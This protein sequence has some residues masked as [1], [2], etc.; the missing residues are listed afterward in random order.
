MHHKVRCFVLS[1]SYVRITAIGIALG[2]SATLTNAATV[3]DSKIARVEEGLL[4]IAAVQV[5]KPATILIRLRDYDVP[6][7]SIAVI[8]GGRIAWAKGYGMADANTGRRV[9]ATTIFQAASLSKPITALGVLSLVREKRFTLDQDV[10]EK[11]TSWK[12]P[13]GDFH[14]TPRMLLNH[15]GGVNVAGF[16]G[17]PVGAPLPS[18]LDVLAG[19]PPS[20]SPPIAIESTPGQAAN[21][22]GGGYEVLQQLVTD[23]AGQPFEGFMQKA[24]LRPLGMK[25]SVFEEPLAPTRR[26][27]AAMGHYA[28][29]QQIQGGFRVMPELAAA[30]LW[31]TPSD[32]ARYV[33][34]IQ[35]SNEG[36][37]AGPITPIL[38]RQTL[39][40][41]LGQH[42]LGPVISGADEAVRFGNDGFNEGYESAY[43]GYVHGGQG[44]VV[45]ANSGFAF[46]LIEEVLGSIGR[47]YSW[48]RFEATNQRPPDDN[49]GQQQQVLPVS[50]HTLTSSVGDYSVG[51]DT[52]IHIFSKG[53]RLFV[54]WPGNGNAEIFATASGR[55][56]C[57]QLTFSDL[58]SP[59]L[60]FVEDGAGVTTA[61]LG[62]PNGAARLLRLR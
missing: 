5:G 49:W 38:A 53:N 11:L 33:L 13:T 42:G 37:V 25:Q 15:T 56:F 12:L 32:I 57:P 43:V 14:V 4:P 39:T 41:G 8:D 27:N 52:T 50:S 16:S 59:W 36:E 3:A 60:K 40:A 23:A 2:A 22:S 29:G 61:I 20:N 31:S 26:A 10:N 7:L 55:L 54:N 28:G 62:A 35:R 6:G 1:P 45:M 18:L 46:M 58:G 30:G 9:S 34:S 47:A 24:V 17:Y 44:A 19:R 48:P 21:Y 51:N